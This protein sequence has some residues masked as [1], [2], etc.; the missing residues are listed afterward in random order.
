L[1]GLFVIAGILCSK[2]Q[3]RDS[4]FHGTIGIFNGLAKGAANFRFV[5]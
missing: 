5:N 2:L 3:Q 1:P 4:R